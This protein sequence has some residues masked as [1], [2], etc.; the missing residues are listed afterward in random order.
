MT[1]AYTATQNKLCLWHERVQRQ[2]YVFDDHSTPLVKS[3]Y[4]IFKQ[5]NRK[6]GVL[7]RGPVGTGK[8]IL[9][10][11]FG[12]H[13]A[14]KSFQMVSAAQLCQ[15]YQ[16]GGFENLQHYM[17]LSHYQGAP[18]SNIK[19]WCID[20][21]GA[22]MNPNIT[23]FGTQINVLQQVLQTIY[24]QSHLRGWYHITTNLASVQIKDRYGARVLSRI[25]E[26][27]TIIDVPKKAPDRRLSQ[28]EQVKLCAKT[29]DMRTFGDK[30]TLQQIKLFWV[31]LPILVGTDDKEELTTYKNGVVSKYTEGKSESLKDMSGTLM[32]AFFNHYERA[33]KQKNHSTNLM[34][35]KIVYQLINKG[36]TQSKDFVEAEKEADAI[37]KKYFKKSLHRMYYNKLPRVLSVIE[38]RWQ[39]KSK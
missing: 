20:D 3:L 22:E 21:L 4:Q 12:V 34:R 32:W 5:G 36:Y 39:D 31:Y 1:E 10:K 19:G 14:E 11:Y 28:T 2:P 29:E 18:L 8:S 38:H 30:P 16:R 25:C 26:L 37:C 7:L 35:Q 9:M 13:C 6:K 33:F 24:E 27:F 15:S 23:F 17:Q